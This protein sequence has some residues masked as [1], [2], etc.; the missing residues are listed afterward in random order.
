MY[1]NYRRG[2]YSWR[3][4]EISIHIKVF[5]IQARE[6]FELY[7]S[8]V[9]GAEISGRLL[10]IFVTETTYHNL[11]VCSVVG[12]RGSVLQSIPNSYSNLTLPSDLLEIIL[13]LTPDV[14]YQQDKAFRSWLYMKNLS[15]D[16]PLQS[17]TSGGLSIWKVMK[18]HGQM[19]YYKIQSD[20]VS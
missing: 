8:E 18:L 19:L 4:V 3:G 12:S 14:N 20:A 5:V 1:N 2:P 7:T 9:T 17:K 6:F 13:I 15:F 16:S 11:K 10:L